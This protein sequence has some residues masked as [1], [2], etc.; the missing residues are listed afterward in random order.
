MRAVGSGTRMRESRSSSSLENHLIDQ[1][2]EEWRRGTRVVR[3]LNASE[4]R[5]QG[6]FVKRKVP[7]DHDKSRC[8]R[9]DAH[10]QHNTNTPYITETPVIARILQHFGSYVIGAA[11]RCMLEGI[12]V[13]SVFADEGGQSEVGNLD[14]HVLVQEQVLWL[15]IAM[16]DVVAVH[17]ADTRNEL[18]EKL[19]R[20]ILL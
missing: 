10:S 5:G 12:C 13:I 6:R 17:V 11:A 15:D 1:D 19:P 2:H 8:E 3:C 7:C 18:A 4:Q 9:R 20:L 16:T 14:V